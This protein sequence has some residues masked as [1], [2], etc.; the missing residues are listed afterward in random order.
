MTKQTITKITVTD[1]M[2]IGGTIELIPEG[3]LVLIAGPNGSGKSS[4]IHAIEE[5]IDPKGTRFIP[6]PIHEGATEAKVEIETTE[7][8]I[9]R[10]WKKNDAG[11]LSAYALDGAKYP[12]GKEFVAEVTGGGVFDPDDLVRLPEKDQREHLL[13]LVEL[14]FDLAEI[15]AKRKGFFDARTDVTRDRKKVAAQLAGAAP[16]DPTVPTAEKSATDLVKEL[17]AIREHNAEVDR[18]AAQFAAATDALAAATQ[19]GQD[20]AAALDQAKA[21]YRAAAAAAAEAK[22]AAETAE[23][24]SPDAI[25]A[26]LADVDAVNAKVREQAARAKIAAE[27]DAL[28]ASETNLTEQLAAIDKTKADGLAAAKFPANLSIDDTG[29]T[30]NGIPFRQVNSAQ[31]DIAALDLYTN[32][33]QDLKVLVMKSGDRLDDERLEGYRKLATER[34]F[35]VFMERDRGNS[36]EV[37]FT[38]AGASA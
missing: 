13:G 32:G 3:S 27:L 8:T 18:K 20:A 23:P 37:G 24:K 25:T 16:A 36:R 28:T 17:D 34:N 35:M 21:D 4:L 5:C 19:R 6:K 33:N 26:Q 38:I 14:P 7:A 15:D 30:L 11:T 1:F 9:K 12:S 22:V 29:I 10:V 31:Q 2:G